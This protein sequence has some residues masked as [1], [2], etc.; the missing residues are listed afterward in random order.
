[1]RQF[2]RLNR[3]LLMV[4]GLAFV[5]AV[6]MLALN[7]Q[8]DDKVW[9]AF[10]AWIR[11]NPETATLRAYGEKL[12]REGVTEA[13]IQHRLEIIRRLFKEN[14]LKGVEITYDRIFSKPLTGDPKQD[15]YTSTP[16]VF[17]M[18]SAKKLK[19]G[20]ALDVGAGQGRNSVWLAREGWNVTAIDISEG[21]LAAAKANAE[22]AGVQI[23]TVKTS[24][25]EFDFGTE[26]WDLIVMILSWAPMSDPEFVARLETGLRPGGVIIF[27]HVLETSKQK[28][29]IYVHGL[30]VN[31]LLGYIQ[32]FVIQYYEEGVW[33]GDWGG[34]PA[35]L[36]RLIGK[37]K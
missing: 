5:L 32:G 13:E 22:S 30:P 3:I 37:K 20:R 4:V 35:E 17:L 16:S 2:I 34:P 21:G 28:F 7:G 19:P 10:T 11:T 14:P 8:E 26:Q 33:Q 6:S 23:A 12:G 24:Y 29:P 36:V 31:A 9:N 1:M 27:E 15:G 25:Q 18:E